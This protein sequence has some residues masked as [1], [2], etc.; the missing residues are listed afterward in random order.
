MSRFCCCCAV[1]TF[2]PPMCMFRWKLAPDFPLFFQISYYRISRNSPLELMLLLLLLLFV[3]T[4]SFSSMSNRCL[5]GTRWWWW[6]WDIS[7]RLSCLCCFKP[8]TATTTTKNNFLLCVLFQDVLYHLMCVCCIYTIHNCLW[9]S[10]NRSCERTFSSSILNC[11]LLFQ[12]LIFKRHKLYD[13]FNGI[14]VCPLFSFF[15]NINHFFRNYWQ[16]SFN[17]ECS[18]WMNE[19]INEE[20]MKILQQKLYICS[21]V[22]MDPIYLF[23][24]SNI[25]FP[26]YFSHTRPRFDLT[27]TF[28]ITWIHQFNFKWMN[29]RMNEWM[30]EWI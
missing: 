5:H 18:Q 26:F 22:Q 1:F 10:H 21:N 15:F 23:R 19:W 28:S 8:A 16:T 2:F 14:V 29:E 4:L 9:R 13:H 27:L 6:W 24:R 17:D 3:G 30:N 12:N 11:I 25:S 20:E 7:R